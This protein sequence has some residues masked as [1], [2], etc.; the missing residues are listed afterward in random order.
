MIANS[1]WNTPS[2]NGNLYFYDT[3]G[4]GDALPNA[5]DGIEQT[6]TTVIGTEYSLTLGVSNENV[7]GSGPEY[8][9]ILVNG[10]SIGEFLMV[11][12]FSYGELALPWTTEEVYFTATSTS[13][14]IAFT[15]QGSSLGDQ[16]PLIAGIDL[17]VASGV[18]VG[19][20]VPEPATWFT[21]L[22]GLGI[23]AARYRKSRTA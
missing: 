3:G 21:C 2:Y 11:P 19:S 14:T 8:L 12:N 4:Y 10:T 1:V 23:V 7:S 17:E 15:V 9:D 22:A 5:G 16:D 13:S 18:D 6:V 20:G